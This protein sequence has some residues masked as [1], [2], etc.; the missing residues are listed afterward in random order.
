MP[1]PKLESPVRHAPSAAN[2]HLQLNPENLEKPARMGA[3][4]ALRL[5]SDL[6]IVQ[7][8]LP[9]S[10]AFAWERAAFAEAFLDPEPRRRVRAFLEQEK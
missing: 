6:H 3:P 4:R 2:N 10:A 7:A 5:L 8:G 1:K 9:R